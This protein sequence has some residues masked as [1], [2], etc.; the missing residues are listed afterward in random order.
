[1]PKNINK[2][3]DLQHWLDKIYKMAVVKN[4]K[5]EYV[6]RMWLHTSN[7]SYIDITG[8]NKEFTYYDKNGKYLNSEPVALGWAGHS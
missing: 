4:D 7:M 2:E 1:M 5:G 6:L 3:I 8:E